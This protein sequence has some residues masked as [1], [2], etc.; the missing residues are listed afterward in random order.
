[1]IACVCCG[2]LW[3]A[4]VASPPPPVAEGPPPTPPPRAALKGDL[5][6]RADGGPLRGGANADRR[7][8]PGW[9]GQR[10]DG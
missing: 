7:N 2:L 8:A 10:R 6:R 3:T 4:A 1:G 5:E 9:G